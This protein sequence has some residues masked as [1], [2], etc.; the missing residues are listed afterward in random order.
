MSQP[1]NDSKPAQ[2]GALLYSPPDEVWLQYH[3]DGPAEDG[4]ICAPDVTHSFKQIYP[5][6]IRYTRAASE[7]R[8]NTWT[9]EPPAEQG[10]FWFWNGE[11]DS[12]P[13]LLQVMFSGCSGE[14]FVCIKDDC[15]AR[16]VTN[17]AWRGW[18]KKV[19]EP[20]VPEN[21]LN[22]YDAT[23]LGEIK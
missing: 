2:D 1:E 9:Q 13:Y 16:S 22:W 6:D 7:P 3:G 8:E 19:Q 15:Q 20:K 14:Y 18:W 21:P 5:S 11:E 10:P 17:D 23:E 4:P 12:A